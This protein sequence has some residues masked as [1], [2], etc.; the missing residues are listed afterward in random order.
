MLILSDIIGAIEQKQ[1][2]INKDD[3]QGIDRI[4]NRIAP[5]DKAD[6]TALSFL[7]NPRYKDALLTTQA[8]VVLVDENNLNFV[9]D[10][11]IA[12]VVTSPYLAYG[13]VSV[14]FDKT[15]DKRIHQTAVIDDSAKIGNNV[16]IGAFCVI[17]QNASIGDNCVLESGVHIGDDSVI[18]EHTVIKSH[19]VISHNC[20]IG[21]HCLIYAHASIGSDGFGFAPTTNPSQTGWQRIAQLGRVVIGDNVRIGSHTCIDRGAIDDTVIGSDVIIDNLVQIAHNVKIGRGTAIAAKT[22]IA[23]STTIGKGCVIGGAV[24]ISG[25]LIIA[26]FVT[27]TAMTMVI[28]SIDK[29]GSYSSGTV[30]MPTVKWRKSAVHFRKL[31]D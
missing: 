26:D 12:I 18:G 3:L 19:V 21:K 4:I 31:G 29:S 22:G 25:H 11:V 17:G 6:S 14:L 20:I 28:K 2:V 13:S 16:H 10:G 27:I 9:P 15:S 5:L 7:S 23:G 30:A 24:G 1:A 8:S